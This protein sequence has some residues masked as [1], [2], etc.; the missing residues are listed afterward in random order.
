MLN[1]NRLLFVCCVTFCFVTLCRAAD[2]DALTFTNRK[3][4]G[5]D[6]MIQGEYVG[7]LNGHPWGAHVIA[8]GGGTFRAIGYKGGLPGDGWSLE[9]GQYITGKASDGIAKL[10]ADDFYLTV[11]GKELAVF[12]KADKEVGTLKKVN[13]KSKSLGKKPPEGAIVLFDG[14]SVDGWHNGKLVNQKF[15]GATNC[16]SRD[17]MGDHTLH[18]EFRTPF[19]P[20]SSGQARGNSGV[21]VQSR[22]EV[23]VLDSFGLEGKDNECG[24]IYKASNPKVNMCYPPLSWQTYDIDFTAARWEGDKKVKN[25]KITVRHNGVIIHKDL[26]L[27][28]HTPGRKKE[29][30]EPEALFLQNHGNP[31]LYRNIWIVKK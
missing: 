14:K 21:Y 6:Y 22:Y 8:T 12:S 28:Q 4:A 25:A 30:P 17:K 15:L 2:K 27:P 16:Y 11:D 20:T 7:D 5:E 10:H 18:I 26:E 24:G 13:R 1:R 3:A 29:G 19:M 9:A 31:V 23:Q